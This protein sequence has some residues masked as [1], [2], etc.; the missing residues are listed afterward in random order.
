MHKKY[1]SKI[2][3]PEIKINKSCNNN[4]IIKINYLKD[5]TNNNELI[6]ILQDVYITDKK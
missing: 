6:K 4:I 3:T 5:W 2:E 1:K